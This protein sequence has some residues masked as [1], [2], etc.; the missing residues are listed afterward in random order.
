MNLWYGLRSWLSLDG[1]LR[2]VQPRALA[3]TLAVL[4]LAALFPSRWLLYLAYV[5][6][7]LIVAAYL[8]LRH[9]GPRLRLERTLR[10]A[11]AQV[12]DDLEEDWRLENHAALPLLWIEIEDAST[13]PGYDARRVS[14]VDGGE[15]MHWRTAARCTRRGVYRL[16][17]L[18][19]RCADP[20]GLFHYEWHAP[21]TRQVV[22]YP[23]LV[24]LPPLPLPHGQR[25]GLARADLLQIYA[26]P[27]V[28]GVREY[29]PGDPPSRIHWPFVARH[30]RLMVKEFD[31]ERAGALWVVLDL[32]AAVYL[33]GPAVD[34]TIEWLPVNTYGQ[35]SV[36]EAALAEVRPESLADLAVTITASLAARALAEGRTVGL[37]ADNGRRRLVL[38]GSGS[39][40]LWRILNELVDGEPGGKLPLD[41]L[42]RSQYDAGEAGF[43]GAALVVVTPALDA[44]WL[45]ALAECMRGRPGGAMALLVSRSIAETQ[46]T[47]ALLANHG[48]P[49]RSFALGISLPLLDPPRRRVTARVSPLGR[50]RKL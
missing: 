20:F 49:A 13:L 39:R 46:P 31:Q 14:A 29:T 44:R 3:A 26:T 37:L 9:V 42:L 7:L 35:S 2:L 48:I 22:V 36:V 25:G 19:A 28:A 16:G 43:S 45:P 4:L 38:P 27:N 21:A 12:G 30:Q 41:M 18:S 47:E 33:S 8:W 10:S 17:P 1:R 40:Q 5:L 50:V 34:P 15:R 23:P 32:C 6:I 11:W 24:R